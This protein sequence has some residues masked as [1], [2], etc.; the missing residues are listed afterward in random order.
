MRKIKCIV[1]T[2]KNKDGQAFKTFKVVSNNQKFDCKFVRDCQ[3]VPSTTSWI[4]VQDENI[5]LDN[6]RLYPCFWIKQVE[7][8]EE[9]KFETNLDEYFKKV[10]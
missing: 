7:K 3:N 10:E 1:G 9:I 2:A 5:N 8:V 6:R 4:Y